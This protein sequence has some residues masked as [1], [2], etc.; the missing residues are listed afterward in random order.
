MKFKKLSN[1]DKRH[2][3]IKQEINVKQ[4][5]NSVVLLLQM[6]SKTKTI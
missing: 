4:L 6:S 1:F 3:V 5:C 2:G